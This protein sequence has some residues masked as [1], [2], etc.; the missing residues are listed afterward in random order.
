MHHPTTTTSP[1]AAS[2][3]SRPLSGPAVAHAAVEAPVTNDTTIASGASTDA[4]DG[5]HPRRPPNAT[6]AMA[7]T[8]TTS[9]NTNTPHQHVQ[10]GDELVEGCG[11]VRG[12]D[13]QRAISVDR[14]GH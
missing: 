4:R 13:V 5:P 3:V 14:G 10:H 2:R 12:T 11:R 9:D 1:V 8:A 7:A 6:T